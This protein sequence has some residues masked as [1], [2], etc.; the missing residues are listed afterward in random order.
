MFF[1]STRYQESYEVELD[2]FLDL[3][4]GRA[5]PEVREEDVL[6][7][8]KIATACEKSAKEGTIVELEW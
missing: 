1:S 2:Y 7:V 4:S 6:A 5:K 8:T 3:I